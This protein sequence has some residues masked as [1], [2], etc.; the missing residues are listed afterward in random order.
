[1]QVK[2]EG[3]SPTKTET[4]CPPRQL[5]A[6][7][8]SCTLKIEYDIAEGL[9]PTR[10]NPLYFLRIQMVNL[11]NYRLV[12]G[13]VIIYNAYINYSERHAEFMRVS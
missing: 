13:S 9:S 1:M 12:Y 7:M 11:S 3:L 2:I 10:G 4:Q 6:I 8:S 5:L